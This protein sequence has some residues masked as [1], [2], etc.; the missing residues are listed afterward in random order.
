MRKPDQSH[1]NRQWSQCILPLHD[2]NKIQFCSGNEG[3]TKQSGI[4][5]TTRPNCPVKGHGAAVFLSI[6]RIVI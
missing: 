3:G 5:L 2:D 1:R 4:F 6:A